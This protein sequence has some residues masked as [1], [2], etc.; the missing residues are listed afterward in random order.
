MMIDELRP[1]LKLISEW[2][3]PNARVLDMGCGA[4]TLMKYL[5]EYLGVTGYGL[6]IDPDKIALCLQAGINVIQS[7]IEEGL[8][9]FFDE[10]SFDFVIMGQTLQAMRQPS[11]LLD[12]M[13]R[14][15]KQGIVTF[16]NF[17]HWKT[18]QQIGFEGRMP[19]T[20]ALPSTWH[21][22][23]NIHL[24]TLKDFEQL[25]QSKN[26]DILERKVMNNEHKTTIGTR[27]FPNL[28]GEIALYRFQKSEL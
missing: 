10:D 21:D 8:V 23:P 7:D 25:C 6:E 9:D 1:E 11:R 5:G 4:G 13:L 14:I 15:G 20:P 17:G 2:I 16:P 27:L 12:E 28:F 24:C 19:V 18:R 3:K 26:I 22:T